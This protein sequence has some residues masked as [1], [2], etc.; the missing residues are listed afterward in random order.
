MLKKK[1]LRDKAIGEFYWKLGGSHF[2]SGFMKVKE[3]FLEHSSFN[4]HDGS[5]V[6]FWEDMWVGN[7]PLKFQYPSLYNIARKKHIKVATVFSSTPLNISFGR[8][9][10][11]ANR[12]K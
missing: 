8:T 3:H 12:V 1:Y 5:Q 2:W 11:G 7:L 10:V 9:L 6:R 4:V